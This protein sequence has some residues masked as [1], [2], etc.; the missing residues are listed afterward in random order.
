MAKPCE[1]GDQ[2]RRG[3]GESEPQRRTDSQPKRGNERAGEGKK[4]GFNGL[5][6]AVAVGP[7]PERPTSS[8]GRL[9]PP[10]GSLVLQ[11]GNDQ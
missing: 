1:V 6:V 2:Q 11:S 4:G 3:E 8:S 5:C 10:V 7:R 9:G